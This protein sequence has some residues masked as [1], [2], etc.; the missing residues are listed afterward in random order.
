MDHIDYPN[1]YWVIYEWCG[2]N[3]ETELMERIMNLIGKFQMDS[4][5]L[6]RLA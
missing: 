5:V 6:R 2:H 4:L 3:S 1:D